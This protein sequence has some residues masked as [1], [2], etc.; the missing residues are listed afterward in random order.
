MNYEQVLLKELEKKYKVTLVNGDIHIK[1]YREVYYSTKFRR[2]IRK[3]FPILRKIDQEHILSRYSQ[4]QKEV[5]NSEEQYN[6]I[7]VI[8]GHGYT[9]KHIKNLLKNNANARHIIYLWDD[10]KNL[11]K[12][13]HIKFFEERY[14]YNISDCEKYQMN[15]LPMFVQIDCEGHSSENLYDISVVASAHSNRVSLVKRLYEKYKDKYRFFIYF[16]DPEGKIN[17][18]SHKTPLKYSEYIDILRKSKSVMDIPNTIQYGP[19]TRPF[20]AI[21]TH[22][23]VL[24][25]NCRLMDYPLWSKNIMFIEENELYLDENFLTEP[26]YEN[27]YKALTLSTWLKRIKL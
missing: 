2:G 22:T 8:N 23:K 16:Y 10:A 17:F 21:L 27:D 19:T 24:T 13:S 15:Y 12:D 26:Y 25:T 7:L 6:I 5:L 11:F 9:N 3:L 18:F 14:S 1:K 20:D 4:K